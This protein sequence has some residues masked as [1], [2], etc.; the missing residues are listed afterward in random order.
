VIKVFEQARDFTTVTLNPQWDALFTLNLPCPRSVVHS[1]ATTEAAR[2]YDPDQE[3]SD[4][5][6]EAICRA[7]LQW[8][9]LGTVSIE[10]FDGERFNQDIGMGFIDLLLSGF[11]VLI[12]KFDDLEIKGSFQLNKVKASDRVSGTVKLHAFLH[13]PEKAYI[14]DLLDPNSRVTASVVHPERALA[15]HIDNATSDLDETENEPHAGSWP[16]SNAHSPP[17]APVRPPVVY[18]S[19]FM[20]SLARHSQQ[21]LA[22]PTSEIDPPAPPPP[23]PVQQAVSQVKSPGSRPTTAVAGGS[24]APR[25]PLADP[26]L[27]ESVNIRFTA[28]ASGELPSQQ[29]IAE[30]ARLLKEKLRKSKTARKPAGRAVAT[31]DAPDA[32]VIPEEPS[33][34]QRDAERGTFPAEEALQPSPQK[35][36]SRSAPGSRIPVFAGAGSR[37]QKEQSVD[38]SSFRRRSMEDINERL[39]GLTAVQHSSDAVLDNLNFKLGAKLRS[40]NETSM[41]ESQ[42]Q[43]VSAEV[44]VSRSEASRAPPSRRDMDEVRRLMARAEL[45]EPEEDAAEENGGEEVVFHGL[46]DVPDMMPST[47]SLRR[48]L[49]ASYSSRVEDE[50]A[51]EMGAVSEDEASQDASYDTEEFQDTYDAEDSADERVPSPPPSSDLRDAAPSREEPEEYWEY[52]SE[53][54]NDAA[55]KEAH[56]PVWNAKRTD[57]DL[58]ARRASPQ[59]AYQAHQDEE[60]PRRGAVPLAEEGS[61]DEFAEGNHSMRADLSTMSSE[62]STSI[63]DFLSPEQQRSG[64]GGGFPSSASRRQ[65]PDEEDGDSSDELIVVGSKESTMHSG[66][67]S[68]YGKSSSRSPVKRFKVQSARLTSPGDARGSRGAEVHAR[69]PKSS[70]SRSLFDESAEDLPAP[71]SEA[72]RSAG[73]PPF[74]PD[75]E[76]KRSVKSSPASGARGAVPRVVLELDDL[77]L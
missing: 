16:S 6:Y 53:S 68:S 65:A 32:G 62:Y 30:S 61:D 18:S 36:H 59:R 41:N 43:D 40:R 51:P 56:V 11:M 12:K 15:T 14:A 38:S 44:N 1:I 9:A 76:R 21:R 66:S 3:L 52:Q 49:H 8:W 45:A 69:K 33:R 35:H 17:E 19:K 54:E 22:S 77:E 74:S 26:H 70:P 4:R 67:G 60:S 24:A 71:L 47:A 20:Q 58:T 48:A 37:S 39:A 57:V 5:A 73:S 55:E 13:V 64:R 2:Y 63:M 25:A 7:L 42:V 23:P 75:A 34:R 10:V 29:N 72:Y 31:A 50:D 27:E 46:R 28:P